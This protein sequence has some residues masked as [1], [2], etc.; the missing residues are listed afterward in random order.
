MTNNFENKGK[1]WYKEDDEILLK[2]DKDIENLSIF[3]KRTP[4]AIKC[5]LI[6]I[7]LE[8]IEHKK[9]SLEDASL[10]VKIS[11]NDILNFKET[12]NNEAR[13]EVKYKNKASDND[14]LRNEITYLKE[15]YILIQGQVNILLQIFADTHPMTKT[16]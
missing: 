10:F 12:K 3:F 13:K 6:F 7:A 11:V 8:M 9:M 1:K 2:S 4:R 14:E 16:V 15:Q 5:R